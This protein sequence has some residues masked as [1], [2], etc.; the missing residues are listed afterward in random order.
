MNSSPFFRQIS[1]FSDDIEIGPFFQIFVKPVNIKQLNG[2]K[3]IRIR[4]MRISNLN[5][6]VKP[7]L[8]SP[9]PNNSSFR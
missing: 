7:I 3:N 4:V 8:S 1:I 6:K 9:P 2:L 5:K